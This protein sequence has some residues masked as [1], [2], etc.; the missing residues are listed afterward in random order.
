MRLDYG[1]EA[2]NP[3]LPKPRDADWYAA[4]IWLTY[5]FTDKIELA[6][7]ADDFDDA[8]GARTSGGIVAATGVPIGTPFPFNTGPNLT[9][10]TLTLNL[11]PF[12]N[13]QFRPEVRWDHSDLTGAFDGKKDQIIIGTGLAYLF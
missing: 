7:R 8:D 6:L 9:S 2:G 4:G 10:L 1:H 5:D 12:N 11:K 13:F 3:A